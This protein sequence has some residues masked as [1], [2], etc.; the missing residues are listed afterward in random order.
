MT[1]TNF[2][3]L[4]TLAMMDFKCTNLDSG[5]SLGTRISH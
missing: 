5:K 3:L 2:A 1:T 4:R